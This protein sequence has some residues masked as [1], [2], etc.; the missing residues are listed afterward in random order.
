MEIYLIRHTTPLIKKGL[1]YGRL[2]VPLADTFTKE[3]DHIME[4]IPSDLVIVYSSPSFRCKVLAAEISPVYQ[5]SEAL[6]ELNFGDWEGDTWDTVDRDECELWMKDFV[7]GAPPNGET[8]LEMQKRVLL[9]LEELLKQPYKNV[10]IVTHGGVIRIIL[11]HYN[12]ITL[13]DSFA[14][15]IGMAEVFKLSIPSPEADHQHG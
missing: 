3:K 13:K 14:L 2:D 4:Q 15:K 1:I 11:A 7:N 8:M 6:Y 9:F 10:G 12:Q 5:E